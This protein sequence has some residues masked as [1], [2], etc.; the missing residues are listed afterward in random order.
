[1][2]LCML[3]FAQSLSKFSTQLF[4][5]DGMQEIEGIRFFEDELSEYTQGYVYIGRASGAFGDK[6]YEDSILLASSNDMIFVIDASLET[7]VNEVLTTIDRLNTWEA[8]LWEAATTD[9]GIQQMLE[10]SAGIFGGRFC[11]SN[12]D[13]RVIALKIS[14]EDLEMDKKWRLTAESGMVPMFAYD[15]N[16][17][18][19]DGS[20]WH[21]WTLQPMLYRHDAGPHYIGSYLEMDGERVAAFYIEERDRKFTKADLRLA[22]IL[23]N[24][25]TRSIE[26]NRYLEIRSLAS[27]FIDMIE[28]KPLV[29]GH[30][31]RLTDL[32]GFALPWVCMCFKNVFSHDYIV[33]RRQ[34]LGTLRDMDVVNHPFVYENRVFT[35]T[36]ATSVGSLLSDVTSFL[37]MSRHAIGISMPFSSWGDI[38]SH[39]QQSLFAIQWNKQEPGIHY[40][41]D[42]AFAYLIGQLGETSLDLNLTHPALETLWHYDEL[43]GTELYPTLSTYLNNERNAVATASALYIHRNSLMNRIARIKE[44]ADVSLDNPEERAYLLVSYLLADGLSAKSG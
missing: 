14:P 27:I 33:P 39:Y 42:H 41:K 4:I 21:D 35:I 1:M 22:E 44:L 2:K 11:I 8:A 28:G 26:T 25:I 7:V 15:S 40:A 23:S 18:T 3:M 20:V 37:D 43:H 24:A 36:S 16:L 17:L 6:D 38:H 29:D 30:I 31:D 34:L 19:E 9:N 12:L 32:E 13:G 10:L 5:L